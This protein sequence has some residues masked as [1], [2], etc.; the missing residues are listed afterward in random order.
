MISG[1]IKRGKE[2]EAARKRSFFGGS[3]YKFLSSQSKGAK[4]VE[5]LR[6]SH[7]VYQTVGRGRQLGG[8]L[9]GDIYF[10]FFSLRGNN[11]PGLSSL[12]CGSIR[13]VGSTKFFA[14]TSLT[15]HFW[16]T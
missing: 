12:I 5:R 14:P 3:C 4:V 9:H 8:Q 6:Y 16:K 15:V 11:A 1:R 2:N 7:R 13:G 10:T